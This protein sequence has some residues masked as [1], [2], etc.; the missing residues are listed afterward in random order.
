MWQ[1][2]D[3][4]RWRLVCN[5]DDIA[6]NK[7]DNINR[8]STESSGSGW[9]FFNEEISFFLMDFFTNRL[10]NEDKLIFFSYYITRM[11]LK[12][13]ADRFYSNTEIGKLSSDNECDEDDD[14][15]I[16]HYSHQAIDKKIVK[17]N[18]MLKHAWQYSDR[19]RKKE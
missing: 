13:I 15:E 18:K 4:K 8:I 6:T 10:N 12:E 7:Q 14:I 16:S 17:I 19:W 11:T 9:G 2:S 5:M 3:T 1:N